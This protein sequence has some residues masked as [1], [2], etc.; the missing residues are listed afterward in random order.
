MCLL[1]LRMRSLKY[2]HYHQVKN[3]A[4]DLKNWVLKNEKLGAVKYVC[5]LI[6]Y[7]NYS[8]N[9]EHLKVYVYTIKEIEIYIHRKDFENIIKFIEIFDK[10][11]WKQKN[12]LDNIKKHK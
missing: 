6:D 1:K 8:E 10:L 3:S 12:L 7:L 2:Q 11:Y 9:T 4:I 5:F